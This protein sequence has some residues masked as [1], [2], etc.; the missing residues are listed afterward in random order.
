MAGSGINAQRKPSCS[1]HI[2]FILLALLALW[3]AILAAG[4]GRKGPLAPAAP[5]WPVK[6][7]KISLA[8]RGV[9]KI[10]ADQ[11]SE[12]GVDLRRVNAEDLALVHYKR[13]VPIYIAGGGDGAIDP[14]DAIYFFAEGA[15]QK[16]IPNINLVKDFRPNTQDFLLFLEPS[17]YAPLRYA[18]VKPKTPTQPDFMQYP[19]IL[20]TGVRHYEKN[21]VWEFFSRYNQTDNPIDFIFWAKLSYPADPA[22]TTLATHFSLPNPD[23]REP[24]EL[25]ALVCGVTQIEGQTH[26]ATHRMTVDVNGA[27]SQTAEWSGIDRLLQIQIPPRV[28]KKGTNA[29]S[30]RLEEPTETENRT[31]R[32]NVDQVML[33]W[34]DVRY[35]QST[36]IYNDYGEFELTSA[37]EVK[38]SA[39]FSMTGFTSPDV[40]VFD[41]DANKVYLPTAFHQSPDSPYYGV[42]LEREP[43]TST[44]IAF[45]DAQALTPGKLEPVAVPGLFSRPSGCQLLILSHPAFLETLQPFVQWK[46]SRGLK[47]DLVNIMDLFNEKSGGYANPETMRDYIK[48]VYDS[49]TS[50]TLRYVLLVGDSSSISKYQ[51]YLPA[52]AYLQS[53]TN[54]NDNYFANFED[55]SAIPSI[56]VGRFSVRTPEQLEHII[57]K[58]VAYESGENM[59]AWRAKYF[60]I[61]ASET[62]AREDAS[63]VIDAY[64]EPNY[65]A[66][67]LQSEL[68]VVPADYHAKLTQ[69]II[70]A[71]DAGNMFTIFFGHGE[72]R[73]GR[74]DPR[75]WGM[76][77]ISPCL[78][79][80]TRRR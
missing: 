54:A 23:L 80:P 8:D 25:A 42:N 75:R 26:F 50:P 62:W 31:N 49:Q 4:C 12:A 55:P 13:T 33:D 11:L 58:T 39:R 1:S 36:E 3:G 2:L 65:L 67:Y 56:A 59:G 71:F 38:D 44:L 37:S 63:R 7:V 17:G 40:F 9:Y 19:I 74:S 22:H 70:D 73:S 79:N 29:I 66:D 27:F 57:Q 78:G 77:S 24:V 6:A 30:F 41:Q 28:C 32:M 45:T 52:Y 64:V 53:G 10:T 43:T 20:T 61:A 47:V 69:Q 18:P 14:K 46:Q 48:H 35:K 51:T 16:E 68:G 72:A 76:N 60:I 21:P 5:Q 34:F 15:D